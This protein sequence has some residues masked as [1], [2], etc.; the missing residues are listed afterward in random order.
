[1]FTNQIKIALRTFKKD[2]AYTLLNVLGLTIG[3]TFSLL[4]VF[5]V[6]D[7]LSFDQYHEEA[8]QIFRIG[9]YIQ[10]PDKASQWAVT[11]IPLAVTL[12]KE[13]PEVEEATRIVPNQ[14]LMLGNGDRS[15]YEEKIFFADSNLFNVFTYE[16]L[17]GDAAAALKR[18][19]SL[20][21]TRSLAIKYF[22][23]SSKALGSSLKS[24][25]GKLYKITGIIKDVPKNSHLIFN[26]L[27][28]F[29][30][31]PKSAD[32]GWGG[33]GIYTYVLL[34]RNADVQ[35]FEKKLLPLY[36]K[37]MAPIFAQYKIKIH[38]GVQAITDIHLHSK[39]TAEPEELGSMS[40]I[41][42]LLAVAVFMLL[43]ASINYMNLTTARS[44]RRA[45]EIG[46]RKVTGSSKTQLVSQFLTESVVITLISLVLSVGLLYLLLPAFN[47]LSGKQLS[48]LYLFKPISLGVL[49]GILLL[50]GI[51]GGSYPA[52]Y[53]AKFNPV[54]VLKGN[55][56][57]GSSNVVL[58]KV[59]VTTQFSISMVMIICTWVVYSQLQFMREMDL[60]FDR[61]QVV[62]MTVRGKENGSNIRKFTS[63]LK[64]NP[65]VIG[66]STANTVPGMGGMGFNLFSLETEQ[67]FVEKGVNNF[68]ID[69]DYL[70]NL[71]IKLIKGRN[72]TP[73]ADTAKS[74]IVNENLVKDFGWKEP[75]G[76]KLKFP[77]DTSNAT[78]E[79]IGVVKDFHQ[80]SLYD[81]MS[82][83]VLFYSE[84]ANSIQVKIAT[85][86]IPKT[87]SFI[88]SAWKKN[89]QSLPFDYSF[90]DD[91]Y[92][93]Q[94]SADQ[95]RGMIFTSF[96]ILTIIITCL[97]LVGLIAF[98][99]EQRQKEISIRKIMGAGLPQIVSLI[100][101]SF[102]LL[103]IISCLVAFPVAY[104]F[105]DKWLDIF[106]YKA[107]M[108]A[109]IFVLSAGIVLFISMLTISFHTVKVAV[110]NP[111]KSL[112]SE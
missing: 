60:G 36:D 107:G 79:V 1:M 88:E 50:V 6:L 43:I 68:T 102:V 93:S 97:G 42:I 24:N 110:A 111:V 106:P 84:T 32:Q 18:P 65:K 28:S 30:S 89:F 96:S 40:Y 55:L 64:A 63:T 83:L 98:T 61:Q 59:L 90:L 17:A 16:F 47:T 100:A 12:K 2:R 29:S 58:R 73:G 74:I 45:K 21:L 48:F 87:I 104:Y 77:G 82:P 22:G 75:L 46:I 56:A 78:M 9:S 85:E 51:V 11:Q 92:D 7:E 66:I 49:I 3:I 54:S 94:Y 8:G 19:N 67:G 39:F 112:R 41:Y 26:G 57:K 81:P 13:Y 5:Y 109:G 4:L 23:E 105:M 72:F 31:L 10:E 20:V 52:F 101:G 95:K 62:S 80:Q 34:N 86:D 103:V 71:G 35:L 91:D 38:Y 108:S 25:D 99:T 15:F 76:K 27:I 70:A 33:F 14:Q 37:Y 53:L 69:K 44:A